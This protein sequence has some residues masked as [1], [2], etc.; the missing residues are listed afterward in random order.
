[1]FDERSRFGFEPDRFER[2]YTELELALY[3]GKR[4]TTVIAPLLGLALD[5]G[6]R[7]LALGDGLALVRGDHA[8][9]R[10]RTR[11]CGGGRASPS[12][13]VA[14]TATEE[15]SGRAAA[16]DGAG[17]LSPRAH[18]AAAVRAR[19]LLAGPM[20][21][22]RTDGGAWQAV[23]LGASGRPRSITFI[24]GEH[25]DELRA[26]HNL[27]APAH[28]GGRR[29]GVGAGPLRDGLRAHRARSRR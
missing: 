23:A 19:R 16:V 15:R 8:A 11:R 21:W 26:F 28:A 12:V 24:S 18:R 20:G 10:A 3:E 5:H 4:T 2:A 14:L 13:L 25:E 1:M 29:A 7:E 17:R 27:I 9:R 6:T 22:A